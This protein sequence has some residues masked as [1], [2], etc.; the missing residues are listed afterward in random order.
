[1]AG[2]R[3]TEDA[4]R[5]VTAPTAA[6]RVRVC[7]SAIRD[8][9]GAVST[10]S[11]YAGLHQVSGRTKLGLSLALTTV[12]LWSVL[13]IG[14]KVALGGLDAMTL[15]WIRFVAATLFLGLLLRARGSMPS[16]ARFD[17]H[18]WT[19]LAVAAIGL[20]GNYGLYALGLHYTNAGT[21]QVLIQI[22]PMLFTL[23]GIFVFREKFALAQWI[24]LA[25]LV[26]G[27]GLFSFDQIS[28]MID[29]LDR[30]YA[31]IG[32]IVVSAVAWAAYGLAQKQL[33]DRMGA[34]QIMLC[35]Y[36]AGALIFTPFAAPSH[37]LEMTGVQL[38]ALVF[39]TAN[40]LLSYATFSE[41]L[42][43][44][45]ATRVSAIISSVPLGTLAA[46]HAASL[47]APTIFA[48]EAISN[49]GLAGATLVA[50]GSLLT[51]LGKN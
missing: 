1:L 5:R 15:T 45:E 20:A 12:A 38:G 18:H 29:G 50:C 40:M 21:A 51:S 25:V 44:V 35:L 8:R 17:R 41:A 30:Y 3:A 36:A 42:D 9:Q 46:I 16:T 39:C 2:D 28:H 43:H 23:G 4:Q 37:L 7:S 34:P 27:L 22:A 11:E 49:V 47:F 31:G 6:L 19:L 10:T 26:T 24:G 32:F 14:L 13:P 48:P 33:L